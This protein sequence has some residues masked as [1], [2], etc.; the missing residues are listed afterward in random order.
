MKKTLTVVLA[1]LAICA[2]VA[3]FVNQTQAAIPY[4]THTCVG[5]ELA[6]VCCPEEVC[7]KVHPNCKGKKCEVICETRLV[8]RL[9]YDESCQYY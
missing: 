3:A 1:A 6:K 7:Y 8:C 9:V 2:G 5:Y 4:C